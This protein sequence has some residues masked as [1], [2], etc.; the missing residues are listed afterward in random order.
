MRGWGAARPLVEA[1]PPAPWD[2]RV[3]ARVLTNGG[4]GEG[5]GALVTSWGYYPPRNAPPASARSYRWSA[6]T[7]NGQICFQSS[8]LH[9]NLRFAILTVLSQPRRAQ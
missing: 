8:L 5:E 3:P 4:D 9:E 6:S 2:R 7:V 1:R